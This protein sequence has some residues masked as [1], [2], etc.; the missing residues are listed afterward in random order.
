MSE[1]SGIDRLFDF[2]DNAI[3]KADG[4][5]NRGKRVGNKSREQAPTNAK[6][7][8]PV[9]SSSTAIAKRRFRMIESVDA[10]TGVQL[11]IVT[12]GAEARVE[13]STRPLA[14]KIMRALETP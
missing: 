2:V 4:I 12:D 3:D 1:T 14:E 6:D 10:E 8:N 13:C 9:A 11:F 5:I 7:A